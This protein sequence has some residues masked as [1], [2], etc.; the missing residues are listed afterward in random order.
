MNDFYFGIDI[1]GTFVKSGIVDTYGKVLFQ[2]KAKTDLKSFDLADIVWTLVEKLSTEANVNPNKALGLGIACAGTI[3]SQSGVIR[4]SPNLKIKDYPLATKLQKHLS[5]PI[6][7]VNDAEA[8]V[9]AE[10]HFG[11]G[12][13]CDDFLMI[14]LGTGIGGGVVFNG[15]SLRSNKPFACEVGHIKIAGKKIKC[16]CG[17]YNCFE[18]LASTSALVREIKLAMQ[19]NPESKLWAKGTTETI[20]AVHLFELLGKDKTADLVFENYISNLGNGIVSIINILCPK[21]VIIG[22][23]ISKQKEKLLSPLKTYV[24]NHIHTKHINNKIDFCVS[25]F[26]NDSGIVGSVCLFK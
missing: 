2:K 15:K 16:G 24:D 10:Q 6:K 25:A 5:I 26:D 20:S 14:T 11:A 9:L 12:R 23:A 17:E 19:K 13:N 22:G 18:T 8:V 21:K 4:Y 1:G 3:D 7:V